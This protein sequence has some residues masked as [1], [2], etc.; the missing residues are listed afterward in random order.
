MKNSWFQTRC[1]VARYLVVIL[2]SFGGVVIGTNN[3]VIAQTVNSQPLA[4]PLAIPQNDP[5]L[6]P[7][8]IKRELSP[9]E[10]KRI[11]EE[12]ARLETEARKK[13]AQNQQQPAFQ[14]WFRQLR[15]YRALNKQ[16]EIIALG[17]VG[18]RAWQA[19]LMAELK[20]ISQRL[21]ALDRELKASNNLT[22][23][24]SIALGTSYQQ[25]R[26]LDRAIASYANLLTQARQADDWQLEQKY[27]AILGEI[28][29]SKFDYA[30]AATVY[31]ELL[32]VTSHN[33]SKKNRELYLSQLIKIYSYTGELKLAIVVKK[34]LIDDYLAQ[35]KNEQ[36]TAL[37][38][39]L[40]DDYQSIEKTNL[41]I[42]SY[43]EASTLGTSQQQLALTTEALKKLGS[44]YQKQQQYFLGVKVYR[45]LLN[46]ETKANNSYGLIAGYER[47][48]K[49]YLLLEDYQQALTTFSQ[50]LEIARDIDY[51]IGHFIDLVEQ[52]EKKI[53]NYTEE[54]KVEKV[55]KSIQ[56]TI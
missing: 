20:V 25:V 33:N 21:Q 23:E 49:L 48:G 16:E 2:F 10:R 53:G 46:I 54:K 32:K 4:Q 45:Q 29:L 7:S 42:E 9:L 55:K 56:S 5:L 39:S 3:S 18:A 26:D 38:I 19:N 6:P 1:Y 27:L 14:L 52:V 50:G 31:E 37:K 34:Q 35:N 40:G 13:L 24:L 15:L 43:R 47:L 22:R 30:Q 44:L 36:I 12:I 28:Y 8:N 41:A 51:K 11:R 17:R